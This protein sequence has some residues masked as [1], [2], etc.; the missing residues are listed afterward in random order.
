MYH[1]VIIIGQVTEP[2]E[3]LTSAKIRF[4]LASTTGGD[5][6]HRTIWFTVFASGRLAVTNRTL[7]KGQRLLI[8]GVLAADQNGHPSV[9]LNSTGKPFAR[10]EIRALAISPMGPSPAEGKFSNPT[11]EPLM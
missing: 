11:D 7:Q 4:Y 5:E 10:Y 2:P 1:R 9:R 3:Q 6:K 8:E